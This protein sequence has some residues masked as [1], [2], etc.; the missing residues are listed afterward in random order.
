M[1]DLGILDVRPWGRVRELPDGSMQLY[2]R[3]PA[4]NLVEITS[5]PED[6]AGID[7]AILEDEL[8]GGGPYRY[9]GTDEPIGWQG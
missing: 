4:G 1:K 5:E 9:F 6:R 7:P 3:D 2:L 8:Y